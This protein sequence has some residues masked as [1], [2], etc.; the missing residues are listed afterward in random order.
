MFSVLRHKK[1]ELE[2]SSRVLTVRVRVVVV[3]NLHFYK[4]PSLHM[5]LFLCDFIT[6]STMCEAAE[7]DKGLH[8]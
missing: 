8:Y 2:S 1:V 5:T 4:I 3:P 6:F 7:I